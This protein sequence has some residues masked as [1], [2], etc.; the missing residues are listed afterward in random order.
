MS[1]EERWMTLMMEP[2]GREIWIEML[3]R[4][5]FFLGSKRREV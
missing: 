1:S 4:K 5:V 2:V 3:V